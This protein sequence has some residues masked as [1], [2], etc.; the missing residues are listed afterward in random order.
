MTTLSCRSAPAWKRIVNPSSWAQHPRCQE[1]RRV[2]EIKRYI[3]RLGRRGITAATAAGLVAG[4]ISAA[5]SEPAAQ[6]AV[7]GQAQATAPADPASYVNPL[8]GT[9][10]G[11]N[12]VG[13]VDTFPGAAA[14]F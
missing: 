9:G 1:G 11:G 14:P 6:A 4:L 7:T 12:V 5:P 13:Q 3:G 8:I 2:N 10:S